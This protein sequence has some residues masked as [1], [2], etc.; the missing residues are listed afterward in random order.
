VVPVACFGTLDALPEGRRLPVWRTPVD[1]VFGAPFVVDPPGDTSARSATAAAAEIIRQHLRAH[2]AK[3][4][5][6]TGRPPSA[7]RRPAADEPPDPA[8]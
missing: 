5:A 6:R 3:A 2:L 4:A 1:V 8:R 7:A